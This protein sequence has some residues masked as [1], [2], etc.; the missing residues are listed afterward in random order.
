VLDVII[1]QVPSV[2]PTR[3]FIPD[4]KLVDGDRAAI[5]GRLHGTHFLDGRSSSTASAIS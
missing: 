5:L 4:V 2:L 1:H 3:E